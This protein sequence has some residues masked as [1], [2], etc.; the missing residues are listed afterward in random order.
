MAKV[1]IR[2]SDGRHRDAFA[3]YNVYVDDD[4]VG[5]LRRGETRGFDLS[6]GPHIVQV[7]IGRKLSRA[8]QVS[9]DSGEVFRFRCGPQGGLAIVALLRRRDNAWLFLE[10]D[11]SAAG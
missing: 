1:V 9:G 8:L 10:P 2:R 6:P 7:G 3:V 4:E 11:A 5:R